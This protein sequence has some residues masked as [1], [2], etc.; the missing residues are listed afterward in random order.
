M[1][2]IIG[3]WKASALLLSVLLAAC[4]GGGGGGA[5]PAPPL[6]TTPPALT[7][8]A[9][10]SPTALSSQQLSGTVELG[11]SVSLTLTPAGTS[12]EASVEGGDWTFTLTGLQPGNNTLVIVARDAAGNASAPLTTTIVLDAQAPVLTLSPLPTRTS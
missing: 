12:R 9:V 2:K 3:Q 7:L 4:G 6:D 1:V 5:T 8:T 10:A 11:G